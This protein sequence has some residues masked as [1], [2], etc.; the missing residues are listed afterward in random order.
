MVILILL[1]SG[2]LQSQDVL[3]LIC[4]D[5]D[6]RYQMVVYVDL[7]SRRTLIDDAYDNFVDDD[8][9]SFKKTIEGNV[10]KTVIYRSTGLYTVFVTG[11]INFNFGG[12]CQKKAANKF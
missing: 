1:F 11:K 7:V 9:I 8:I 3:T 10:H 2:N 6:P 4:Q 12:T 5:K